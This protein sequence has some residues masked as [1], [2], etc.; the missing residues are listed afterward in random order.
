MIR[1]KREEWTG[2][3][4]GRLHV[5][6][7][8]RKELAKECGYTAEYLSMVLNCKKHFESEYAKK[9]TRKKIFNALERLEESNEYIDQ[10]RT[11]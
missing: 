4:V 6:N 9:C 10:N 5:D 7:I 3:I 11:L 1:Q 8:T 2:E